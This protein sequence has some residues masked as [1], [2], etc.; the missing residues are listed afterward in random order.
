MT[1]TLMLDTVDWDLVLDANGNIALADA[2]YSM[3]Q[4]V[5]SA[6]RVVVGELWFDSKQGVP[7]GDILGSAPNLQFI[8]A[9]IEAAAL[10]VSGVVKARCTFASFAGRV[11]TGQVQV[12]DA[13]GMV[14]N[15]SF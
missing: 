11:L 7:Y 8:R 10:T 13:A 12:T 4:D 3:A 6:V 9:K 2:P 5:A 14:N 15:V 1:T